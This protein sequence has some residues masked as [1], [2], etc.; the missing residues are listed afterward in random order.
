MWAML[1]MARKRPEVEVPS[2]FGRMFDGLEP[3]NQQTQS[4]F[5]RGI[6]MAYRPIDGAN[7]DVRHPSENAAGTDFIRLGSA[8]FVGDDG[9]RFADLNPRMISNV[10]V[11]QGDPTI[12]M[13][14]NFSG[15]M[16]A[17]GQFLDHDLDLAPQ[18]GKRAIESRCRTA[19]RFSATGRASP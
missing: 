9:L 13:P 18:D 2:S 17:W 11:G 3:L 4:S 16:Y 12:P 19:T 15:M 6:S 8:H 1:A 14:E 10:V 5:G 7:V